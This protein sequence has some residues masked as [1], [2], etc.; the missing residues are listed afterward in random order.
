MVWID[1]ALLV[2]ANMATI[3]TAPVR[4]DPHMGQENYIGKQVSA[5]LFR[6]KL[7]E[8]PKISKQKH[9]RAV[10]TQ[11]HTAAVKQICFVENR[12]TMVSLDDG[13]VIL[14]WE[15]SDAGR[16]GFGWYAP[17]KKCR[18]EPTITVY[19]PSP[20]G[21]GK[22]YFTDIRGRKVRGCGPLGGAF[23]A[24]KHRLTGGWIV[25]QEGRKH[26]QTKQEVN[27]AR[28]VVEAKIAALKLPAQPWHSQVS[29]VAM[30]HT[31]LHR[32]TTRGTLSKHVKHPLLP[33]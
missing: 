16:T 1:L 17:A 11:G 25:L 3:A 9:S 26:G 12:P 20:T 15:Y 18:F 29:H 21:G 32:C 7:V 33:D 4:F 28:R 14:T 22:T 13:G 6:G 2:A 8:G 10:H 19:N 31:L 5:E 27:A 24:H 30:S 23:W